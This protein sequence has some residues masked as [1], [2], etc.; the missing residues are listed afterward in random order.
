MTRLDVV[1]IRARARINVGDE[2][3]ASRRGVLQDV[4]RDGARRVG[5]GRSAGDQPRTSRRWRWTSRRGARIRASS[6]GWTRPRGTAGRGADLLRRLG[7]IER[8]ANGR[9][10]VTPAGRRMANLPL[11]PRMARMVLWGASR[12]PESEAG[13]SGGG[14]VGGQGRAPRTRRAGGYSMQTRRDVG[15]QRQRRASRRVRVRARVVA[16]VRAP[17]AHERRDARAGAHRHEGGLGAKETRDDERRAARQ[18]TR[19]RGRRRRRSRRSRPL[20]QRRIVGRLGRRVRVP[21]RRLRR[22]RD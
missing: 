14:G 11:H 8:G 19:G 2:R 16:A 15:R 21:V 18:E 6:R 9:V 1:R 10:A 5:V 20:H 13:V 4:V 7:A 17:A 12:G 3:V 22:L